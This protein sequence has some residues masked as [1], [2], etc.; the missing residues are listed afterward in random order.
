MAGAG[1]SGGRAAARLSAIFDAILRRTPLLG[2]A[3]LRFHCTALRARR[4]SRITRAIACRAT[5]ANN[6]LPR[7]RGFGYWEN[8]SRTCLSVSLFA[9]AGKV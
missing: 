7:M 4:S 5:I 8:L 9:G 1:A 6:H 3:L 2:S